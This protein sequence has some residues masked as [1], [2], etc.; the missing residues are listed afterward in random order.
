MS[1]MKHFK[2]AF[3]DIHITPKLWYVL[4]ILSVVFCIAWNQEFGKCL[5][6][7]L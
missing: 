6:A 7:V 2:L 1:G 4:I 3:Q 5:K